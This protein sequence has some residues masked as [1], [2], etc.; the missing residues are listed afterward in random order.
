VGPERESWP[1]Q[2]YGSGFQILIFVFPVAFV[3]DNVRRQYSDNSFSGELFSQQRDA[4][5]KTPCCG[6]A[7]LPCVTRGMR[8]ALCRAKDQAPGGQENEVL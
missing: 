7:G 5:V 1:R 2:T 8:L 4:R 3:A 6:V